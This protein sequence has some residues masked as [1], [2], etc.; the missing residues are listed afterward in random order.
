[1]PNWSL[2]CAYLLLNAC[3]LQLLGA[4]KVKGEKNSR[5]PWK[6]KVAGHPGIAPCPHDNSII[7]KETDTAE[8]ENYQSIQSD[9]ALK[10]VTPIFHGLAKDLSGKEV[11]KEGVEE[12]IA[13][14]NLTDGYDPK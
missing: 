4:T 1:M 5:K 2:L 9:D 3:G 12:T 8:F 6:W 11:K 14:Q 7:W 13:L 10:A